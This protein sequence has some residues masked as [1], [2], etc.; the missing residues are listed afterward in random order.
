MAQS[1]LK[2]LETHFRFGEN[3][4]S[5]ARLLDQTRIDRAVESLQGLIRNDL[6]GKS[7]LDIGSG[8]GL[9]SLAAARL[10]ASPIHAVDI[11][12]DSVRTSQKVLSENAPGTQFKAEVC[13]VF[14]LDV[15]RTGKFNVV[16]SWGVLHHT[17]AMWDAIDR[18]TRFVGPGGLFVL[19][20]YNKTPFCSFWKW[21][22]RLYTAAPG[23][24]KFMIFH[25]YRTL[26]G[27]YALARL[28]NPWK[29]ARDYAARRGM[30]QD[31]DIRD[32]LGGYPYES[33]S[34][35][36]IDAF[37]SA[38]Q[39]KLEHSQSLQKRSGLMGTGCAEYTYRL[40]EAST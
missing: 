31:H 26:A 8:S 10:G 25:A 7:F 11:D 2:S 21:E 22:K 28:R 9:S 5:F 12:P 16:H 20:I 35:E 37:M 6:R 39:F 13:S 19:A 36:E 38:R 18:A 15:Q 17:G 40:T 4:A 30:E 23:L 27:L 34:P 29:D 24:G 33:A 32:W 14:D 3:W 1:D